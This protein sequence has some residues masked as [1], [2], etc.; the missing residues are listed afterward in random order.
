VI[1]IKGIETI[2]ECQHGVCLTLMC[3]DCVRVWEI[4]M[5]EII[6]DMAEVEMMTNQEGGINHEYVC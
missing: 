3:I 5:E 6:N 4:A 2:G 1:T